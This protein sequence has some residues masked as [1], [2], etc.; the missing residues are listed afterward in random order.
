M[1]EFRKSPRYPTHLKARFKTEKGVA[2]GD[3]CNLSSGGFYLVTETPLEAGRHLSIEIGLDQEKEWIKGRCEVTWVNNIEPKNL[4]EWVYESKM[5]VDIS[6]QQL[7]KGVGVKFADIS[8]DQRD[9]L[10]EYL[11]VLEKK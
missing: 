2:C 1:K 10:E 8:P 5:V 11:R 6:P 3:V 4:P 7:F 9:Q